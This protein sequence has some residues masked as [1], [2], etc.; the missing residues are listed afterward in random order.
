[1]KKAEKKVRDGVWRAYALADIGIDLVCTWD[2][3]KDAHCIPDKLI[4]LMEIMQKELS[5]VVTQISR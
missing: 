4:M 2:F 5:E 1:M 3:K